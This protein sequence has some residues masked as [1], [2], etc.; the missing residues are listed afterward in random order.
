L[1][2]PIELCRLID[3][4]IGDSATSPSHS[5]AFEMVRQGASIAT[6]SRRDLIEGEAVL[7]RR[8]GEIDRCFAQSRRY[9]L[10]TSFRGGAIGHQIAVLTSEGPRV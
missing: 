4:R 1:L 7:M 10:T 3:L 2:Y 6:N 5:A 8:D 9:T